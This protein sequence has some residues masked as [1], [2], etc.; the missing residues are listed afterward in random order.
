[1]NRRILAATACAA[2]AS[3]SFAWAQETAPAPAPEVKA[4]AKAEAKP[5]K[6]TKG[7]API[8]APPAGKGQIVF[9]RP[10]KYM[11][12]AISFKV[13]EGETEIGTLANSGYFVATVEPGVHTYVVHSEAK[14]VLNIEV[15]PDETYYV[16]GTMAMG[17]LLYRPNL[18]PATPEEFQE[19][20]PK[21]KLAK[22][23]P[24]G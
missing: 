14:D 19:V 11:G 16:Q 10:G 21:L 24:V 15:E 4:E 9:F 17:A 18:S 2:L 1:M 22:D 6:R 23:A 5:G 12:M 8:S 3:A 13:R 20:A 7:A